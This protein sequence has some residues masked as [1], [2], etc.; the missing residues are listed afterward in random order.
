LQ[1]TGPLWPND[2][3][4]S[5]RAVAGASLA[6]GAAG[7]NFSSIGA[8]ADPV[9]R[10]YGVG[11]STVGLMTA[12]LVASHTL[13]NIPGGRAVDRFGARRMIILGLVIVALANV[14]LLATPS[15]GLV[16]GLRFLMGVGTALGFVGSIDYVRGLGDS[17]TLAEGL[18]GGASI[19]GAGI[20]LAAVPPLEPALDWRAPYVTGLAV[21]VLALLM[22]VVLWDRASATARIPVAA[23]GAPAVRRLW[24][25]GRLY[26]LGAMHMAST[27][28]SVV[29]GNWV[30]T[31]LVRYA[32]YSQRAAGA[33]GS[34]TLL[35]ALVS[36]PA[37]AALTRARPG[38]TRR[39]IAASLLLGAAGTAVLATAPSPLLAVPAAAAVGIASGI[40]FGLVMRA[41][42]A[43]RPEAPATAVGFTNMLATLVALVATPLIG[44]SFSLPGG[45]RL[46]FAIIAALWAGALLAL[47]AQRLIEAHDDDTIAV[48]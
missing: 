32:G 34:L 8:I 39:L 11:L 33:V 35:L 41:V 46:G 7:W 5:G 44:L 13:F 6:I 47:P 4:V 3:R 14:V 36:R 1:A 21:A 29:V 17:S 9:G 42:A 23:E 45:G 18:V 2:A 10:A 43:A 31:L 38:A 37:A 22:L 15:L 16:L 12:A 28:L 20:A 25:D 27:G 30:V 40:P 24:H 26:R 48:R 19:G